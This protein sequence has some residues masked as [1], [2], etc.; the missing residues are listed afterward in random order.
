M[1]ASFPLTGLQGLAIFEGLDTQ[2]RAPT[3]S[4]PKPHTSFGRFR[5]LL[6]ATPAGSRTRSPF[7]GDLS[8]AGLAFSG[9]QTGEICSYS[10]VS[11]PNLSLHPNSSVAPIRGLVCETPKPKAVSDFSTFSHGVLSSGHGNRNPDCLN[12]GKTKGETL[13]GF[14]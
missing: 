3:R 11:P 10:C 7:L 9:N 8:A 6:T 2:P 1:V 13:F 5:F 12:E 4:A 14:Y